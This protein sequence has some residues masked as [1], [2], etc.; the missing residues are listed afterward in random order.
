LGKGRRR[1]DGNCEY[2]L[3]RRNSHSFSEQQTIN[4]LNVRGIATQGRDFDEFC[5]LLTQ[6]SSSFNYL[7][8]LISV[9]V[10]I[11]GEI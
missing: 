5:E 11:P 8:L 9:T 6:G 7:G 2:S 4:S 10:K 1:Q 3:W